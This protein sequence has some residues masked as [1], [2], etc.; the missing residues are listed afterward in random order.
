MSAM[1]MV[2]SSLEANASVMLT[3]GVDAAP[4]PL[5]SAQD[6]VP[7]HRPGKRVAALEEELQHPL[8]LRRPPL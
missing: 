7:P 4:T 2:P 8:Q 6:R 3:A 5:A 1:D